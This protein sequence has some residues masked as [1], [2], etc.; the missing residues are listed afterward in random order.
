MKSIWERLICCKINNAACA[1]AGRCYTAAVDT[2]DAT[3]A[4]SLLETEGL[5]NRFSVIVC[6]HCA[7]KNLKRS[8][9]GDPPMRIPH[10]CRTKFGVRSKR[11][12]ETGTTR[13]MSTAIWRQINTVRKPGAII[14]T[15]FRNLGDHLDNRIRFDVFWWALKRVKNGAYFLIKCEVVNRSKNFPFQSV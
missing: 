5:S 7:L 3:V 2:P 12:F 9:Y 14:S 11:D 8:S 15:P 1:G 10:R 13:R 4:M 6:A